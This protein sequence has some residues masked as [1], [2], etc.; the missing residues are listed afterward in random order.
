MV[1]NNKI[2][3]IVFW[4]NFIDIIVDRL[5]SIQTRLKKLRCLGLVYNSGLLL[6]ADFPI[7]DRN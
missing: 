4:Y 7:W 6:S 3:R 5:S 1:A 2:A